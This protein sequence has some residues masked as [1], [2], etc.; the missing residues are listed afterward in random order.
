MGGLLRGRPA[1]ADQARSAGRC[2]FTWGTRA[3]TGPR[4]A[5]LLCWCAVALVVC[6]GWSRLIYRQQ[7]QRAALLESTEHLGMLQ[8]ELQY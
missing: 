1:L 2:S 7:A 3:L 8:A 6:C 5:L 4:L